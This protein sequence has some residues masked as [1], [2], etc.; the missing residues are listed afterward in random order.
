MNDLIRHHRLSTAAAYRRLA[1]SALQAAA[2]LAD[3]DAPPHGGVRDAVAG[4]FGSVLHAH[5]LL[6]ASITGA[7]RAAEAARMA[8]APCGGPAHGR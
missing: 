1:D 3:P 8:P 5:Q 6:E 4:R 2:D 7:G